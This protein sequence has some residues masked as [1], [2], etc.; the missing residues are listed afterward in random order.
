MHERVKSKTKKEFLEEN[1]ALKQKIKQLQ[2]LASEFKLANE[3][4]RQSEIKYREMV[5]F[6]PIALFETDLT[7]NVIS[8]NLAIF[9]TFGYELTDLEIGLNGFQMII[10]EDQER[11]A[12]NVRAL[13]SGEKKG[14]SE[15]TGLRKDGSTFPVLIF[16]SV[17]MQDEKPQGF[18]GA[19]LDLTEQKQAEAERER[20]IFEL[21]Q[22]LSEI[23]TLSGLLPICSSCKKIRDDRGY[24]NQIENYIES[25]SDAS[26]SHSICPDCARRMYPEFYKEKKDD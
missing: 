20:L 10:P 21:K 7:G 9:K 26:F 24:W 13:L 23:K 4:Y 16:T 12:E 15:Y 22:A 11:L 2:Q 6:I 1:A 3:E 8:Q 14:P 5:D 18:R 19:I 25:H 17:I